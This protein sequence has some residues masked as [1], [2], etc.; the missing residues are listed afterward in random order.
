MNYWKKIFGAEEIGIGTLPVTAAYAMSI[1][2]H[3][4]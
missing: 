3:F 2:Y 1:A 4:A